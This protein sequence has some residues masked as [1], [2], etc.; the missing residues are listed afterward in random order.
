M[1]KQGLKVG[2]SALLGVAAIGLTASVG[3]A[4]VGGP[5]ALPSCP[6]THTNCIN[7]TATG[8]S[9]SCC[10]NGVSWVCK[11]CTITFDCLNPPSPYT[12]CLDGL[13]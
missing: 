9:C 6:C 13:H 11:A 7:M 12:N 10:F 2:L 1:K 8:R 4:Q 5:P 3:G